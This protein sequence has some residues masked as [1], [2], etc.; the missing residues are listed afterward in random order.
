MN[1]FRNAQIERLATSGWVTSPSVASAVAAAGLPAPNQSYLDSAFSVAQW[2]DAERAAAALQDHFGDARFASEVTYG[3]VLVPDPA[4]LD[5]RRPMAG[6]IRKGQLGVAVED[7]FDPRLPPGR[8]SVSTGRD[9]TMVVS[10]VSTCGPACGSYFDVTRAKPAAFT[11]AGVDSRKLMTRQ[12]WGARVLQGGRNL[13]DCEKNERWTFTLFAGEPLC[14]GLAESG[15][16]LKGKI[17]FRLGKPDRG[18][19]SARIAP[20]VAIG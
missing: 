11:V 12:L 19:G 8:L 5:T 2:R 16:V 6:S 15:T 10:V 17:R 9:W 20:A 3:V 14:E 7:V 13:P 1:S 18:I 4:R